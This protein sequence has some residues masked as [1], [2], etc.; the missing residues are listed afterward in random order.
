MLKLS[1]SIPCILLDLTYWRAVQ[2]KLTVALFKT[3]A[4]IDTVSIV[5]TRHQHT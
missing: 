5:G 3:H 1:T 4:H 2:Q